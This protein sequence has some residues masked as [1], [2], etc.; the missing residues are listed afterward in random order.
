MT[1]GEAELILEPEGTEATGHP[2]WRE[3]VGLA[4]MQTTRRRDMQGREVQ[5]YVYGWDERV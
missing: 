4:V 2:G 5:T 1:W 3:G